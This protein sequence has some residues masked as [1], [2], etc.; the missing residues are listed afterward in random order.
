MPKPINIT[1]NSNCEITEISTFHGLTLY[2][3]TIRVFKFKNNQLTDEIYKHKDY[4]DEYL[5]YKLIDNVVVSVIYSRLEKY[6]GLETAEFNVG[7][8]CYWTPN[9]ILELLEKNTYFYIS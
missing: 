6:K 3:K 7:K 8:K 2:G 9:D 5:T 1:Y 4:G